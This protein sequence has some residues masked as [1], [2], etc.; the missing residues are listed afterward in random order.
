[1]NDF[2]KR[3]I[4]GSL[5]V[6]FI[7]AAIYTIPQS[8]VPFLLVFGTFTAI[9]LWEIN[10]MSVEGDV[11]SPLLSLVDMI[12]GVGVFFAFFLMYVGSESRSIWLLPILLYFVIRIT[13]QLYTPA[14]NALHSVQRSF[15]GV[16]YVAF[17]LG[18]MNSI[19]A[20]SH[21]MMLL[22][23]FIL[24][25]VNDSGAYVVG[26]MLGRHK[27][28]ERISP[29]KSW[30]GFWGGLLAS[31]IVALALGHYFNHLFQG[32]AMLWAWGILA[33]VVSLFGTLGDLAESL[34]K[35]TVGVKDSSNLIPGHGGI[36]DR[37]DSFL[38]A[39]PAALAYFI[40]LKLY[41]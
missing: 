20:V 8:P 26:S 40:I 7:V 31:V 36:L 6:I 23:V 14:I 38:M 5:Y 27:L 15:M 34:L 3:I 2:Y 21:P 16:A 24:L 11:K 12:G 35:R 32:P 1:M 13:L 19:C 39:C 17:P 29:H 4:S 30:E 22:A 28:F 9:G 37:I 33:V 41:F 18:M 25:W 10:H